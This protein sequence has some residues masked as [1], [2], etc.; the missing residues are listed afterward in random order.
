MAE[1]WC[2]KLHE[3]SIECH[4][5]G[6][7]PTTVNP[8]AKQ[9]MLEFGIDLSTHHSKSLNDFKD[10]LFD[11]VVTLCDG[12]NFCVN[13]GSFVNAKQLINHPFDDP[14]HSQEIEDYRRVCLEIRDYVQNILPTL[15]STD[16]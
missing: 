6:I 13:S 15:A 14:V 7:K 11:V 4:S 16:H 10:D 9:V 12:D 5:A 8:T 1:G 3:G 2:K